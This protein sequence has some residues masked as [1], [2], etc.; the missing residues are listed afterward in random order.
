MIKE[1]TLASGCFWCTETLFSRM[2]GVISSMPGYSG[3]SVKNPA[4]R[5]VCNGTT[6]HAECV[7]L[8]FDDDIISFQTLIEVFFDMHDP[9]TLNRQGADVGTQYR[10][11]IFYHDEEQ[12]Q[13]AMHVMSSASKKFENSIVTEL[14]PFTEFYI[15][16][17]EHHDYYN[18]NQSQPYCNL[19][20]SP[21]VKKL[22]T[23]YTALLKE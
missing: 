18:Q 19:V 16:E 20:I 14:S 17:V 2:Q 15:A 4:Y 13:I 10:S 6:G 8:K 1:A 21:K 11:A 3:G 7:H 9:T 12:H 5:E 22:M 23:S